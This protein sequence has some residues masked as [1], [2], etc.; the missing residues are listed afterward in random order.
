MNAPGHTCQK[1]RG[2]LPALDGLRAVAILLVIFSHASPE[3]AKI[4]PGTLGV[5]LF[6]ALS[7]FLITREMVAE[8]ETSG[9]FDIGPFY[10]RRALRLFPAL[11]CYLAIFTGILSAMGAHITPAHIASGLLYFTNYYNI[12]IGYPL[13]NPMPILWSLSVEEHYYIA[14]PF[15]LLAWRGDLKKIL[16]LLC[17][18]LIFAPSWRMAVYTLCM[19]NPRPQQQVAHGRHRY[20]F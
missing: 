8:I 15:L 11:F 7:G 13:Y 20:G 19:D 10:I 2:Y 1:D 9:T 18:L 4:V 5:I 12:Y 14:F 3:L 6:F 17:C 16:P